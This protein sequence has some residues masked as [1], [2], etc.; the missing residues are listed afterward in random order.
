MR[1]IVPRLSTYG[2]KCSKSQIIW[3]QENLASLRSLDHITPPWGYPQRRGGRAGDRLITRRSETERS[4]SSPPVIPADSAVYLR[5][6]S[7]SIHWTVA[8]CSLSTRHCHTLC[9][10]RNIPRQEDIPVR[11]D[12]RHASGR[13]T[14]RIR[15]ETRQSVRRQQDRRSSRAGVRRSV[16]DSTTLRRGRRRETRS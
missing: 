5:R 4:D 8:G 3:Y 11:E 15:T 10:C 6:P 16:R 2:V 7:V 1:S 13:W 12:P 14:S 9:T